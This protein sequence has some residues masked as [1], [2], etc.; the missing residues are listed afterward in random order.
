M[1]GFAC[2]DSL[3]VKEETEKKQEN[4]HL[5]KFRKRANKLEVSM[6][7]TR[8]NCCFSDDGQRLAS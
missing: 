2:F 5:S 8:M 1:S 6:L 4:R 3:A 7:M